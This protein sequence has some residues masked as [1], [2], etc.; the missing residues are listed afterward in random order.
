MFSNFTKT[1]IAHV[2]A[3]EITPE[4]KFRDFSGFFP[5]HKFRAQFLHRLKYRRA[6]RFTRCVPIFKAGKARINPLHF[7]SAL[8]ASDPTVYNS[9]NPQLRRRCRRV[10]AGIEA[11][12]ILLYFIYII[13]LR[14]I[15]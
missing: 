6:A 5:R 14:F 8:L 12:I 15:I 9:L 13:L 4:I 10:R 1:F 3:K 7:N 2:W 11:P